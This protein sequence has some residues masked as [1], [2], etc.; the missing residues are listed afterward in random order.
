MSGFR[1]SVRP[2]AARRKGASV[3]VFVLARRLAT[4]VYRLIRHGQ[5]YVD[6]GVKVYEDRFKA[7][8][9]RACQDV[10]NQ[11]G[12]KLIPKDQAA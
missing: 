1:R 6:Q 2:L 12:Y 10:A 8:R 4:L 5:T 9:L 7:A 3:A 11:F